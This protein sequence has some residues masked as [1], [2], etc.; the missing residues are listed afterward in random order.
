MSLFLDWG[1]THSSFSTKFDVVLSASVTE[2]GQQ[3]S[4]STESAQSTAPTSPSSNLIHR[5]HKTPII[6]GAATGSLVFLLFIFGG[7]TFLF[8]RKGRHRNWKLKHRLS[9]NFKIIPEINSHPP[10]VRNKNGETITPILVDRV[11]LDTGIGSQEI[12]EQNPEV[13][14][15]EDEEE[16]RNSISSPVHVDTSVSQIAAQQD[17]PQAALGDVV[18]E[19]VRLRTQV[20]QIIIE[21]EAE[22]VHGNALDPLP[23]YT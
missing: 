9:P 23:A 14:P 18:A 19:V 10:P 16:R 20:Q 5:N 12:V 22:R 15:T 3:T 17:D 2:T 21:R 7:S 4:S 1:T 13:N 6:I 11:A 8:I